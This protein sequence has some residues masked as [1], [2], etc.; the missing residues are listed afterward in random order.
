MPLKIT[1][2]SQREHP[3]NKVAPEHAEHVSLYQ[4]NPSP[5][6]A[7]RMLKAVQ[8]ILDLGV[9]TYGG[10]NSSP[11]LQSKARQIALDALLHYDPEKASVKTH[12]MTHLRGLQRYNAQIQQGI[13]VPEQVMLDR[14][15]LLNAEN[16]FRDAYDRDPSDQELAEHSGISRKRIGYLRQYRPPVAEGQYSQM[17]FGSGEDAGPYDPAVVQAD[18]TLRHAEYLYP[19]LDGPDQVI[20]EHSLGLGGAPKLPHKEIARRLNLSPSAVTQRARNI[21]AKLDE[22]ADFQLF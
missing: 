16:E 7:G 18:P 2:P 19:D 12:L 4:V 5:E 1:Y 17:T 9:R 11:M 22:L 13:S 20:L 10:G 8:P 21:Q 15:R 6:N 3:E 14:Q